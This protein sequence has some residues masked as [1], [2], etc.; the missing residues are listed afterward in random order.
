MGSG[1]VRH[2]AALAAVLCLATPVRAQ[3]VVAFSGDELLKRCSSTQ[4]DFNDGF[5]SIYIYGVWSTGKNCVPTG[6]I[7]GQV[8]NVIV[9][10][11][12]ANSQNRHWPAMILVREAIQQAWPCPAR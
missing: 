2:L 8:R 9:R 11:L 10:Y 12:E 3:E 6:V 4:A 1:S 7:L 5:C